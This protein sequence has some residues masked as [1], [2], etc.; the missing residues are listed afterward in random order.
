[1]SKS[2]ISLVPGKEAA[3][4][5]IEPKTTKW[6]PLANVIVKIKNLQRQ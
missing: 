6:V 2:L 4:D 3:E 5:A 1:M